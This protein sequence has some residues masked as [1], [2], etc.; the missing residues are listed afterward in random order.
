MFVVQLTE[1]SGDN[2]VVASEH[3]LLVDAQAQMA[4]FIVNGRSEDSLKLGVKAE[5]GTITDYG[6]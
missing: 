6:V 3:T 5:D 1:D 4:T 2:W